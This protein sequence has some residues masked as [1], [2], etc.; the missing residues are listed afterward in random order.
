V[1]FPQI[2]LVFLTAFAAFLFGEAR[3][4]F[5]FNRSQNSQR[6]TTTRIKLEHLLVEL[7]D[8]DDGMADRIEE[9]QSPDRKAL[10]RTTPGHRILMYAEAYGS[11]PLITHARDLT[12]MIKSFFEA[13]GE[14]ARLENRADPEV[15]LEIFDKMNTKGLHETIA[16]ARTEAVRMIRLINPNAL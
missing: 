4:F 7:I 12:R 3:A 5:S 6:E 2:V 1:T 13:L 14:R 8:V 15:I 11:E 9:Y 16:R 10:L